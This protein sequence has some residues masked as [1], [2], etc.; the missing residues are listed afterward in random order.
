M[1]MAALW[2]DGRRAVGGGGESGGDNSFRM[3]SRVGV[4]GSWYGRW[5]YTFWRALER[6]RSWMGNDQVESMKHEER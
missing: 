2:G 3:D 6:I 4:G 5:L 1:H